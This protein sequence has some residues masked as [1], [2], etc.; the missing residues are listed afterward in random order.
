MDFTCAAVYDF[1]AIKALQHAILYKK[2]NPT[3]SVILRAVLCGV[4]TILF[5]GAVIYLFCT[6][7]ADEVQPAWIMFGVLFSTLFF[8]ALYTHIG[9]PKAAYRAN[10]RN[11]E[12]K[13]VYT[14]CDSSFTADAV[15]NGISSSTTTAYTSLFAAYRT[16]SYYL[17]FMTK[18]S[19]NLV[20][21]ADMS[22]EQDAWLETT[23]KNTLGKS[24]YTCKF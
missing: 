21:R 1:P 23:L 22:P 2:R 18:N 4:G 15:A 3:L 20:S 14:F 11:G 5:G 8:I 10:S 16:E 17:L 7:G 6:G 19:A 9:L 12:A 24:Y 13:V